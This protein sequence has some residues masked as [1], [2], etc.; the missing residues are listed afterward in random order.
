VKE[1]GGGWRRLHIEAIRNL[2]SSP[3]IIRVM[4]SRRMRWAKHVARVEDKKNAPR[5]PFAWPR[6]YF[7][8]LTILPFTASVAIYTLNPWP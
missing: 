8:F 1:E 7:V 5:K 3:D 4:K 6:S 2:P